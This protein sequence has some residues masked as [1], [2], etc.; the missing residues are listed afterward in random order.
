VTEFES[1]DNKRNSKYDI[2]FA[3]FL[4]AKKEKYNEISVG[5]IAT[6]AGVSRMT[7]YRHFT[8]KEDVFSFYADEVFADFISVI[9]EMKKSS[10]EDFLVAL[11]NFLANHK[12]SLQIL[13]ETK[14]YPI[15]LD[16]YEQYINYLYRRIAF[17][18]SKYKILDKYTVSFVSGGI[19]NAV[20]KW[21]KNNCN[22]EPDQIAHQLSEVLNDFSNR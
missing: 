2:C 11:F 7:F 6:R 14:Q 1:S 4:L 3:L 10:V 9:G 16:K 17:Q 19:Y 8:C 15:M 18:D 22:D 13:I 20:Y 21:V 12:E 5:D